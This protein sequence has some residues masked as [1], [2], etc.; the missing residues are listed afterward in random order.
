MTWI[1]QYPNRGCCNESC[2]LASTTGAFPHQ[3]RLVAQACSTCRRLAYPLTIFS[4]D[5]LHHLEL[6]VPLGY[7]FL[8]PRV[9]LLNVTQMRDVGR[10]ELAEGLSA[11]A[12]RRTRDP[13]PLGHLG[14]QRLVSPSRRTSPC[15]FF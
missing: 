4:V 15:S 1:P 11:A 13:V 7:D 10:F 8:Q 3:P 9:L 2:C 5:P 12:D 14:Y 6:Q